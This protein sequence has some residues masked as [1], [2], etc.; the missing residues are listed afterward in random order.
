M[1]AEARR[2][3]LAYIGIGSNLEDPKQQIGVALEH[4]AALPK[5]RL[6]ECSSLYC[7]EPLG[8]A[9]QPDFV[10]AV[11]VISSE[12]DA[13]TLLGELKRIEQLM[14]RVPAERWGPR[15][16]DLDLLVFGDSC[17][18]AASLVVPHPGIAERNFVLLP[19]REI[20]PELLIPRLGRVRN[21]PV[22]ANGPRI[23][24]IERRTTNFATS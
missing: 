14:G 2:D 13:V 17:I 19:L 9:D 7:S 12:L 20:A 11:A 15:I 6:L 8:P 22:P 10:N 16:I 3:T 18:D 24:Q 23:E 21:I 1:S 4:L 5:S